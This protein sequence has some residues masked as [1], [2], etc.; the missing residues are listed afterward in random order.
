MKKFFCIGDSITNGARNE[1]FRN[2][3]L[4]LNNIFAKKKYFFLN[5]SV[6]GET[7]S[8]IIKRLIEI[9]FKN[10]VYA[11]LFLGGT[12]DSKIPIP[13]KIF[14]KNLELIIN[15][16]TE[17]K[18]RLYFF[19]LPPIYSG[20]PV[21]SIKTGNLYIKKYNQIIKKISKKHK[22]PL[23]DLSNMPEK[24][25]CD[26]IHTNNYGCEHIAKLA[27]KIIEKNEKSIGQINKN[28]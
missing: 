2:Y 6:N 26:G 23:I 16:C 7:T 17:K 4:E 15:L 21:Y 9:I 13:E 3:S 5:K 1:F 14:K 27:K 10:D 28:L 19:S 8:E 12:N 11:I 25:F 20:L 18:I 22:L 24:Y